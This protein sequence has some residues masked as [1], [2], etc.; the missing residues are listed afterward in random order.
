M[1]KLKEKLFMLMILANACVYFMNKKTKQS[2]INIGQE[3]II[4]LI[5]YKI[6]C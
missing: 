5:L 3:K 2:L 1:E 6:N 4:Q